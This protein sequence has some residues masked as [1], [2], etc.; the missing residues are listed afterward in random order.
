MKTEWKSNVYLA[1]SRIQVRS[2][3]AWEAGAGP[4]SGRP[5][6][7]R[8]VV[9]GLPAAEAGHHV[10][11]IR[12]RLVRWWHQRLNTTLDA[13]PPPVGRLDSASPCLSEGSWAVG[14]TVFCAHW[15]WGA[16]TRAV[17]DSREKYKRNYF[18]QVQ[19][20]V[21][22]SSGSHLLTRALCFLVPRVWRTFWVICGLSI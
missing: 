13:S 16:L 3:W 12:S 9:K 4:G 19:Q 8:R 20:C 6:C 2:R 18:Q 15:V 17:S 21:G 11:E 1:R 22:F 10:W 14:G 5:G 7:W